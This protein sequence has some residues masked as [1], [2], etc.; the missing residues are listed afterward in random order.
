[1]DIMEILLPAMFIIIPLGIIIYVIVSLV[2]FILAAK[3]GKNT[4]IPL[5]N[6]II[7]T[8]LLAALIILVIIF[9]IS[10]MYHM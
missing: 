6:L 7:S 1:M 10:I 3:N 4:K 5:I 9:S 2:K 8:V